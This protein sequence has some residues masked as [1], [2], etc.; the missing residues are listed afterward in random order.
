MHNH[1]HSAP[2]HNMGPRFLAGIVLN[3]VF[4]VVEFGYGV[5]IN[6]CLIPF[7]RCVA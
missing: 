1:S 3:F 2:Q 7:G 5:K 6:K 4:V